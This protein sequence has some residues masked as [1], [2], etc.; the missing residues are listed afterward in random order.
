M[1][2]HTESVHD[3]QTEGMIIRWARFYDTVVKVMSFGQDRSL[4]RATVEMAGVKPG[5]KVLDVG[6]GTGDLTLA[7]KQAAGAAGQVT[8]ID[9]AREMI[10]AAQ[11][12]AA[13]AGAE[14]RFRA[15]LIEHLPFPDNEFDV[16]LSSIMMHH[17]P[18]DLKRRGLIEVRR[19]LRPA[20]RLFIVD[21]KRPSDA[22]SWVTRMALLHMGPAVGVQ[23]LP[24]IMRE[25]GFVRVTTGDM[26][27]PAIGFAAG[28]APEES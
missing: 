12:K 9:A 22:M 26:S 24:A 15:E 6:C 28:Q 16:V 19:V 8:G 23:D 27:L 3:L 18:G 11:R 1:S 5:D 17:L 10:E 25:A 2:D 4:R 14:V 21:F 20:G 7:A 13:R